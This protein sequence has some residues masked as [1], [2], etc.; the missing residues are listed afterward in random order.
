[1]GFDKDGERDRMFL[2]HRKAL[3]DYATPLVGSRDEA[4][5]IVHD[6]YLRFVPDDGEK[7]LPPKTYL[8]RIVRNL[9]FNKRTRRKRENTVPEHDIP[10]WALPQQPATPEDDA[11]LSENVNSV[12]QALDQMPESLR[13]V[14]QLYRFDGLTLAQVAQRLGVS[15]ATAHRMLREAMDIVRKRIAGDRQ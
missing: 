5:D 11:L 2:R 12:M 3:I 9:S 8:F 10:W 4:E 13:S 6:A 14:L 15:T 7:D 1:M